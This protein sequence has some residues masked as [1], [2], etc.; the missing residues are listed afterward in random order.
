[1]NTGIQFDVQTPRDS[2]MCFQ[3]TDIKKIQARCYDDQSEFATPRLKI[4]SA[5]NRLC[6]VR[7]FQA[8]IAQ[9][10]NHAWVSFKAE[11]LID[12]FVVAK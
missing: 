9:A 5:K 7:T 1:M 3:E 12:G 4:P 11:S 10:Y 2:T 6:Q 8:Y